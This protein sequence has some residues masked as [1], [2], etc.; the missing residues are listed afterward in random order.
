MEKELAQHLVKAS[1]SGS[2]VGPTLSHHLPFHHLPFHLF[3]SHR[4]QHLPTLPLPDE[5]FAVE[6]CHR[7][8]ATHVSPDALAQ[9]VYFSHAPPT[10][11]Q[12]TFRRYLLLYARD[13]FTQKPISTIKFGLECHNFSCRGSSSAQ[14]DNEPQECPWPRCAQNDIKGSVHGNEAC[15]MTIS[16]IFI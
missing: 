3:I 6:S 7:L 1:T 8:V 5:T 12:T 2:L 15:R 14:D 9:C 10:L 16:M 4:H 13:V 11:F